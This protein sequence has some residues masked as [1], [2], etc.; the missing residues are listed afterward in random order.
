MMTPA[1][2]LL[3]AISRSICL[4]ER[5]SCARKLF[6]CVAVP[7]PVVHRHALQVLYGKYRKRV[8]VT[9]GTAIGLHLR[10]HRSSHARDGVPLLFRLGN[11][12]ASGKTLLHSSWGGM[13]FSVL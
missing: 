8:S 7:K 4:A 3:F 10:P 12:M 11:Q 6:L 13:H 5:P 2:R 1:R 9:R